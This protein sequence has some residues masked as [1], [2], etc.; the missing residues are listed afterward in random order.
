MDAGPPAE[1]LKL[2]VDD[3]ATLFEPFDASPLERRHLDASVERFIIRCAEAKRATEYALVILNPE[4][5]ASTDEAAMLLS[6]IPKHFADRAVEE[7]GRIRALIN[8]AKQDLIIG[9][10]F[11]FI[12]GLAGLAALRFLPR[13]L[14]FFVEQGLL[15]LGWVALWRPVDLLLYELRPLR[16]RR[17][18]LAALSRAEV[19]LGH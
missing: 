2:R 11:L 4:Q 18:L 16:K 8:E 5:T 9:L 19:R 14:G 13:P 7:T 10:V 12:C 15:V 1:I 6:G 17:D 3:P